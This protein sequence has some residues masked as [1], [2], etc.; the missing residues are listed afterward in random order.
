VRAYWRRKDVDPNLLLSQAWLEA[1]RSKLTAGVS[2]LD[3][4]GPRRGSIV[5]RWRLRINVPPGDVA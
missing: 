3:P 4:T 5:S 1:C 2:L